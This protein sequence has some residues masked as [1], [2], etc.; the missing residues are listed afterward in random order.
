[1]THDILELT[2]LLGRVLHKERGD[3][4]VH[5][6]FIFGDAGVGSG[7]LVA[8]AA[9]EELTPVCFK[10][11]SNKCGE[12]EGKK[13]RFIAELFKIFCHSDWN[14]TPQGQTW[15]NLAL[16]N[17]DKAVKHLFWVG[18][19]KW[20][21]PQIL[22]LCQ[23]PLTSPVRHTHASR[24]KNLKCGPRM[25][26]ADCLFIHPVSVDSSAVRSNV[27]RENGSSAVL[28]FVVE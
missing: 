26:H 18:E 27:R 23:Q 14:K 17:A 2:S 9:D 11:R 25:C 22:I 13:N 19:K 24:K 10:R 3:V 16:P 7:V 1:M 5:A 28:L 20:M 12:G 6:H 15:I 4:F 8:D 21:R